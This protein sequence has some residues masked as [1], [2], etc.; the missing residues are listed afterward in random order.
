MVSGRAGAAAALVVAIVAWG[1]AGAGRGGRELEAGA[2][3]VFRNLSRETV[4]IYLD[5][6][7]SGQMLGSVPALSRRPLPV[8]WHLARPRTRVRVTVVKGVRRRMATEIVTEVTLPIEE[9]GAWEWTL[10]GSTLDES[11]L[12]G[13][14]LAG[15]RGRP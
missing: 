2:E 12:R 10:A 4:W 11:V 5:G 14:P 13:V 1:C 6:P 9:L 8:P 3:L 7:S 15:G